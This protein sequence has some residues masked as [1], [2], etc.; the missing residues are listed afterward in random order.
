MEVEV[1]RWQQLLRDNGNRQVGL[2]FKELQA[3]PP[4]AREYWTSR[5]EQL[6]RR[7]VTHLVGVSVKPGKVERLLPL[8]IVGDRLSIVPSE[9]IGKTPV[10][11]PD[12]AAKGSEPIGP[13]SNRS[14]PTAGSRR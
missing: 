2:Y 9:A 4:T 5:A 10:S 3:L 1:A 7:K 8:V 12:G 14:S 6:T 11:K 13:V